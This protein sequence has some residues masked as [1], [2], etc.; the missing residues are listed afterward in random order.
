MIRRTGSLTRFFVP[1]VAAEGLFALLRKRRFLSI[2]DETEEVESAGWTSPEDPSGKLWSEEDV[3]GEDGH[4]FLKLRADKK[5]VPAA[6]VRLRAAE[7]IK[8]ARAAA[9]DGKLTQAQ[10]KEIRQEVLPELLA[11]TLPTVALSD[12]VWTDGARASVRSWVVYLFSTSRRVQEALVGLWARTFGDSSEII[13]VTPSSLAP[14]VYNLSQAAIA[15]MEKLK[16]FTLVPGVEV[17]EALESQDYLGEEFLT[18]LWWQ[19]EAVGGTFDVA[20]YKVG[21]AVE[22]AL[23]LCDSSAEGRLKGGTPSKSAEA[24]AALATGKLLTQAR[25]VAAVD[26]KEWTFAL[27]GATWQLS[28]VRVP[29]PD[30]DAAMSANLQTFGEYVELARI[31]DLLFASYLQVRLG[32]TF[33][34]DTLPQWRRW[35]AERRR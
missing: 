24:S 19:C 4:V 32:S 18:W 12:V 11:K 34:S 29:E 26:A 21:I 17:G 20:G 22:D 33:E 2:E 8:E 25:L 7:R 14:R 13:P 6:W 28:G 9:K 23:V 30:E 27:E 16:P 10:L 35:V 31:L 5:T 15:R 1:E 3:L